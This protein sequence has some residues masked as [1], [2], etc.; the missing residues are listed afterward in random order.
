MMGNT[1]TDRNTLLLVAALLVLWLAA[2]LVISN[3]YYRLVMTLVP[4]WAVVGVSWNLLSGYSGMVSFGHAAFFGLGAFTVS[5]GLKFFDLTPWIGIPLAS[6]VGAIAGAVIGFPTFR[7]RGT[8]FALAML[9]YPM[10]FIAVFEWLG[11]QEITIPMK[12]EAPWWYAQFA[13]GRAY[14]LLSLTL[15]A[16]VTFISQRI[17]S[18]RFGMSLLAIKDNE[19]AAEAAGIDTFRWKM[20]AMVVS[21]AIAATAGGLYSIVV[22]VITPASV[23]GIVVS[24]QAMVLTLFGGAGTLWGPLIGAA[25]LVPL[26]EF[27]QA[28]LGQVLPGIQG[29]VYGLAIIIVIVLAPEGI[30]WRF[31]DL[32][33]G[34]RHGRTP[35]RPIRAVTPGV[36]GRPVSA[37]R[38]AIGPALLE[39]RHVS[40][41]YGGLKAVSDVS[42][43]VLEGAIVGIIGP[44]GAG[45]TTLF[46]LLNGIVRPDCGDIVFSGKTITGLK[47]NAIC[48]LGI[49]RTFQVV[50]AFP[51]MTVLGNVV[52]GAFVA[53]ATDAAAADAARVALD[54]VGLSASA[55]VLAGGLSSRE[56]RLMELAR[57]LSSNPRL[58][59]LDEPLAGL[60]AD[61]SEEMIG[62]IRTL[63]AR[64]VTVVI[65]EHTMQAMVSTVDTFIVL[66]HG[67][68]LTSGEPSSV[69]KD[70]RVIEAYLGRKWAVA[71]A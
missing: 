56:L 35:D 6:V 49:A 60:G 43:Q 67:A 17:E 71:N 26:S 30:Y 38:P 32:L 37:S 63:P 61:E 58:L 59:L 10:A 39:A 3:P 42:L 51:R 55:D 22:L 23:F 7:L 8:Y 20:R 47:P 65:I 34:R 70:R 62:L 27:L 16:I 4:L 41:S 46:N 45:K 69:M 36:V 12:R 68:L 53:H 64:G 11:Y 9:A 50:R 29:L 5:L 1:T 2:G 18:S 15:L 48:R 14:L 21:A 31:H 24:A 13:D 40:K 28:E 66:D 57:A 19:L 33:W 54:F 25:V 44:N 52:T